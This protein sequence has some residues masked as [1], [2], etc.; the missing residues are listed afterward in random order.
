MSTLLK[1]AEADRLL[2]KLA[3]RVE[4]ESS[5]LGQAAGKVL[6]EPIRADRDLPPFDRV[7]MD[8]YAIRFSDAQSGQP[9]T[10]AGTAVAGEPQSTLPPGAG[11]AM[12]VMTG[13]PLPRG[14]DTVIPFED[15]VREDGAMRLSREASP[16]SGQF[17]HRKGSDYLQGTELVPAGS[18]LRS[19]ET[20]I[21]ASCGYAVLAVGK[22]LRVALFG[23][24][25]ELVPVD[26][27]PEAH[28]IRQS[29]LHALKAS[30]GSG[31]VNIVR[32]G[33]LPDTGQEGPG[34]LAASVAS[35][36]IVILSG[37]VS[38]G[39]LDWIP[40]AMDRL[41]EKIFHGVSQRPGKPMGVWKARTGCIIFALPGN[42]VSTLVCA[43]RY[44]LP[45]IR[46]AHGLPEEQEVVRLAE[47]FSFAKPLTLFLPVRFVEPGVVAPRPVNNSG[48]Y[49][50][51]TGSDGFI[52]LPADAN[53]WTAG[54]EALYRAWK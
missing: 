21:A 7:M 38:K 19:V 54:S 28:Q 2:A 30:L 26:V 42:P 14:A 53:H 36:D 10:V 4:A 31:L 11:L 41:G 24:G 37:A 12:E 39:R 13:C 40:P 25:D 49:A 29:N 43:H 15:T 27:A 33:H 20:G 22:P 8:G 1:V 35:S 16:E 51:L 9:F 23:T 18:V 50:G 48:D 47:S 5:P 34:I 45:F 44:I 46:M 6:R 52:E 32:E 17:I 3:E